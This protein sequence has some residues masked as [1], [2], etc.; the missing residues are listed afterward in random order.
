MFGFTY[1]PSL[2]SICLSP[3][4]PLLFNN[5]CNYETGSAVSP[6]CSLSI[7]TES[8]IV[9]LLLLLLF[10]TQGIYNYAPETNVFLEYVM[11]QLFWGYNKWYVY[12]LCCFTGWTFC[13]LTL[14]LLFTYS[15]SH[16]LTYL[17]TSYLL[18]Y[19]LTH[20]LTYILTSYIHTYI[21]T[22]LLTHSSR[23][24]THLL[25][26]LL[27]TYLLTYFTS[28]H[29]SSHSLAVVLTLE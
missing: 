8:T 16:L 5:T 21:H 9:L 15:L 18:P 23:S 2:N 27:I 1:Q 26:Y 3:Y 19:L 11:L 7:L 22:Y 24:L 25:T 6:F 17:Y 20:L 28:L 13:A 12:M 4:F 29:L 10:V 14:L